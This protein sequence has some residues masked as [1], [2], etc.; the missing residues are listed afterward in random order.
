MNVNYR[1]LWKMPFGAAV[2]LASLLTTAC[3]A[4]YEPPQ[5]VQASNPTV[6]YK[7]HS[8]QE[9]LR[10]NQ[11]ATT[12][13]NQYHA[14]PRSVNFTNNQDGSKVVAFECAQ[15]IASMP[16]QPLFNTNLNYT[17]RTDQELLYES[18]NAQVYC[19]NGGSPQVISN[20]ATNPDGTRTV[21][22]QCGR[23]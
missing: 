19:L 8:D 22:S 1:F 7:Y 13:C 14:I 17:Y 15:M 12:F 5:Q 20:I 9:L 4:P 2:A 3:V 11:S 16:Q 21:A 6:T 23:L 18:R 10:V